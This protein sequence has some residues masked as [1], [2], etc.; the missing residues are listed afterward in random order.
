MTAL[1]TG[2]SRGIGFVSFFFICDC[3]VNSK[4]VIFLECDNISYV[5]VLWEIV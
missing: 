3:N 1:V 2:G 4:N 5:L